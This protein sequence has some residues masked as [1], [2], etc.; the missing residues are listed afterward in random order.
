MQGPLLRRMVHPVDSRLSIFTAFCVY[1]KMEMNF[2]IWPWSQEENECVSN[3][4]L[5]N[6]FFNLSCQPSLLQW[7]AVLWMKCPEEK[8]ILVEIT[9]LNILG[10]NSNFW[11]CVRRRRHQFLHV[12]MHVYEFVTFSCSVPPSQQNW[13]PSVTTG[14]HVTMALKRDGSWGHAFWSHTQLAKHSHLGFYYWL[15]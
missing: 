9:F 6:D 2:T 12:R 11:F 10:I 15:I 5:L 14:C 1:M 4:P 3:H 13:D 7:E 8:L